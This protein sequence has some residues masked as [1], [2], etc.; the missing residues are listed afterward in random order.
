VANAN[1][2]AISKIIITIVNADADNTFYIDNMFTVTKAAETVGMT[3]LNNN[4]YIVANASATEFSLKDLDGVD[5]DGTAYTTYDTGG[6]V[7]QCVNSVSGLRHLAL[8][9]VQVF[10]DGEEHPDR[11]VTA[12]GVVTLDAYYGQIAIGLGY[13]ARL[14]SNDLEGSP[15]GV[16]SQGKTKRVSEV[17]ANVYRSLDYT[18]GTD[19]KMDA[20]TV[21]DVALASTVRTP[22]FTGIKR[23]PFPSGWDFKKQIIIE[24]EKCLPLHILSLVLSMEI[25]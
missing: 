4:R 8:Q 10:A 15:G 6:E 22:E 11:T 3:E 25:N 23:I 5:I 24:Q 16:T 2:N 20:V 9:N 13:T 19:A 21:R 14:M 12:D 1:K 18:I 17:S 7:R